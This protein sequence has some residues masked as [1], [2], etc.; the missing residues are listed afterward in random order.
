MHEVQHASERTSEQLSLSDPLYSRVC[1]K[2]Q[3]RASHPYN[4]PDLLRPPMELKATYNMWHPL[5]TSRESSAK[6]TEANTATA[7]LMPECWFD[8]SSFFLMRF[9]TDASIRRMAYDELTGQ[10]RGGH[11]RRSQRLRGLPE[12]HHRVLVEVPAGVPTAWT[13]NLISDV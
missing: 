5:S 10:A 6:D 1:L 9:H 4:I 3:Q 7:A 2:L 12:M 13:R 11:R 8:R